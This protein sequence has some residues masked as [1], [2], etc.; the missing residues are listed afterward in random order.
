MSRPRREAVRAV[1]DESVARINTLSG[2]VFRQMLPLVLEAHRDVTK[3]LADWMR[4]ENGGSRFT[5]Q[6]HR[7]ALTNLSEAIGV[8]KQRYPTFLNALQ[9]GG[10]AAAIAA[11]VNVV[12]E[13]EQF[14][15]MFEGAI[16]PISFDVAAAVKSGRA[17]L[18]PQFES[19]AKRYAGT[20]GTRVTN[21]LAVSRLKG[22][23]IFELSRTLERR[24]P[25]VFA[26]DR[27][28]CLRLA[29]T[30]TMNAYNLVHLEGFKQLHED[31]DTLRLRW[32]GSYDSR[33]CPI[34]GRLDGQV[35]N[36]AKG[37]TFSGGY[38]RPPAHPHCRCV[39]TPWRDEWAKYA[40][41]GSP[42]E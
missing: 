16:M 31:D 35:I 4:K 40:R 41:V 6:R 38:I 11:S 34:C 17:L 23:S 37:E 9:S 8:A 22:E 3:S 32:D 25:G 5:A 19:S 13:L 12:G 26:G 28:D 42:D 15:A 18:F 2:P 36:A 29:R 30:E 27:A 21:M 39:C 10:D 14:S 33:R 24:L 7:N 20:L 1:L